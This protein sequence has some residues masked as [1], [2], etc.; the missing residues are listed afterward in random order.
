[1][2]ALWLVAHDSPLRNKCCQ[3][4]KVGWTFC[5]LTHVGSISYTVIS[6]QKFS[7]IYL[8]ATHL[9]KSRD[10]Q[11]MSLA[12]GIEPRSA[13]LP[14]FGISRKCSKRGSF[15]RGVNRGPRSGHLIKQASLWLSGASSFSIRFAVILLGGPETDS[16]HGQCHT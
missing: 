10:G 8:M 7:N 12:R 4:G 15:G 13:L 2:S 6:I 16:N 3:P 5:M 14:N 11:K 9:Q 1:M